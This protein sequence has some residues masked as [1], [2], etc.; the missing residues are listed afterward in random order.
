MVSDRRY[1][2]ECGMMEGLESISLLEFNARIKRILSNV[3]VQR[4]WVTAELSDVAVR[5]GHCYME[6]VQKDE[7]NTRILAK[8]RGV[9]WA[10]SY[11]RLKYDFENVTGMTFS[12]GLKLMVEVTANYH[13]VYG[14]SLVI[15]NINPDY[16]IGGIALKRK[17]IIRRLTQ[18]GIINMNKE[19]PWVEVPQRIAV[20]SAE[21]A[22]GYGDFMNQLEHNSSGIKFYTKLFPSIMQGERTVPSVIQALDRIN[23]NIGFFDC[24]VV[25]RGGGA[26][27][28]LHCFD[29]YNLA[30]YIA[31]FPI[32]VIVGIGHERDVTVLDEVA[33]MRV[34]TPTAAAEWLISRGETALAHIN[35]LSNSVVT[36]VRNYMSYASEQ[37]A[38]Y[39]STVPLVARNMIETA[40]MR[41]NHYAQSI[42][43]SVKNHISK[44]KTQLTYL[45]QSMKQAG[46][47]RLSLEIMKL[48]SIE[49]KI[50][51]L[52]PQN[53]LKRGYSLT[54]KNGKAVTSINQ[55]SEDDMITTMLSDGKIISNVK[56]KNN[57]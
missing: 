40:D 18:E 32:P 39:G 48:T 44:S 5:G 24:V 29:D 37:L 22:A 41:L 30:A 15:T 13:E 31:Q 27:S 20:V 1:N 53:T 14:M 47:Q 36:I 16:T 26:T 35:E 19:L 2:R 34:K 28:E 21:G 51:I 33:A 52:S 17:E 49:E 57:Q 11:A 8:T 45:F 54:L 3:D 10:N 55:V 23:D 38:Y 7:S 9:I 56:S 50:H 25:I 6:L 12:S 4:C 46:E 43:V 42:P